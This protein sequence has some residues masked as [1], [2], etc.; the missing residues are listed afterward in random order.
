MPVDPFVAGTPDLA[1]GISLYEP[2]SGG[3]PPTLNQQAINDLL[4]WGVGSW[5]RWQFQW[6]GI[7]LSY[8][9]GTGGTFVPV[10]TWT[11]LDDG[12][13]RC[14]AA[15][16]NICFPIQSPP[17][18]RCTIDPSTG[19]QIPANGST[20]NTTLTTAIT[21]DGVTVVPSISV[22]ALAAGSSLVPSQQISIDYGTTGVREDI[23]CNGTYGS[24]DTTIAVTDTNGDP[25]IPASKHKAGA[26]VINSGAI[27]PNAKDT[28][29]FAKA[30]ATRYNGVSGHGLIQAIQIGNED[31][32]TY[33]P[34]DDQGKWLAPVA[35]ASYPV[36]KAVHPTCRVGVCAVRK[37]NKLANQHIQT[38]MNNLFTYKGG[39]GPIDWLDLHYYRDGSSAGANPNDQDKD[40]PSIST[41]MQTIRAAATAAG[42][43]PEIWC[44]ET[45]WDIY[46]DG[47]GQLDGLQNTLASGSGP[48]TTVA[49]NAPLSVFVSAGTPLYA[50]FGND[51]QE[52]LFAWGNGAKGSST[53]SV[54]TVSPLGVGVTQ[55]A[56]TPS[57][58]HAAGSPF[59]IAGT[60]GYTTPAN[61]AV[62]L[63]AMYEGVR[64]NT[65]SKCMAFTMQPDSQ[66]LPYSHIQ[67][68]AGPNAVYATTPK[69]FTQTISG[70]YT[71]LDPYAMTV[72]YAKKYPNWGS[73]SGGSS[74]NTLS[75]RFNL[76]SSRS[77]RW[78]ARFNLQAG[79]VT[80]RLRKLSARY[81][82]SS[83]QQVWLSGRFNLQVATST[84]TRRKLTARY[85]LSSQRQS[86]WVT[87]RV[88]LVIGTGTNP[89]PPP[90][91]NPAFFVPPTTAV[92]CGIGTYQPLFGSAS[93][94]V[95]GGFPTS[96]GTV[97][98]PYA[99]LYGGTYGYLLDTTIKQPQETQYTPAQEIGL[100][101][102]GV[103]V[104]RGF[105][106]IVWTYTT[107]RPD[108]WYY[109]QWLYLKSARVPAGY[110]YLVLVQYPS[111]DGLNTPIQQLAR[112]NPPIYTNRTVASF[113]GV[114][115]TFTYV[116]QAILDSSVQIQVLS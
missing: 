58:T 76:L 68:G 66:V 82:L 74:T 110:Q 59:Y 49:L 105:P 108:Y 51:N 56:W 10:Y 26:V 50:D 12:V 8:T 6:K 101:T 71:R 111:Q 104:V 93:L 88:N 53:I 5:L 98:H 11:K 13:S 57:S 94:S 69:S 33:N 86:L 100:D 40:T 16:I 38:W 22:V 54:S 3:T 84:R 83:L 96:P 7:E 17:P 97:F 21:P 73:T 75:G 79:T 55:H 116:G 48:Y 67:S 45:G 92:R 37:T 103:S 34:R 90:D 2:N 32:D 43:S 112:M 65:G 107:M 99:G 36:I 14:N 106:Q 29:Q 41:E 72:A 78:T 87:N 63:K 23:L 70:T 89:P 42:Q 4:G 19:A 81:R 28:A 44:N 114:T 47:T 85:K 77:R 25:W 30:L 15:G 64:L 39:C 1:Y 61:N 80:S 24:G 113:N 18:W 52:L 91:A 60:N 102:V 27:L 35:A 109:L 9:P 95:G 20:C 115:L 31:W 62:Y 46:D